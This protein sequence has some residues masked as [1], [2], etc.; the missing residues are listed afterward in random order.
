L[1]D[2]DRFHPLVR[3]WFG[4]YVGTPTDVQIRAWPQITGGNHVLVTAPTG[5]GKTLAAFLWAINS[6]IVNASSREERRV[7]YI[8]PLKALNNDIQRNLNLPLEQLRDV[9][10]SAGQEFPEIRVAVRS[11]DT[12]PSQRRQIVRHPPE[13]FIT[14]PESLNILLSS[15]SGRRVL[16]GI[17]TVILD[18]IHAV[19]PGRRGTFLMTAVERMISLSGEF[20]RI[21]LSAT[22]KPLKKVAEFVGG[23]RLI[24]NG[25][26][27]EYEK[28]PVQIVQSDAPKRY[29]IKVCY[30]SQPANI[31]KKEDWWASLTNDF[32]DVIHSNQSTLFFTNSRRMVE[33]VTRFINDKFEKDRVYSHHGSLSREIR[34]VVE[35][36]FKEGDLAAIVATSS[37]ELGIDIGSVDQVVLVQ[38][39]FSIASAIQRIGRAGHGVGQV[40]SGLFYPLHNH[41]FMESAVIAAHIDGKEIEEMVPLESPL[42]VLAQVILS[43]TLLEDRDIDELFAEL[44]A[45]YSYRH[46]GRKEFDL[47]LEM[48]AGR[49]ADA[50][51][52]ELKP[53]LL[54][55]RVKNTARAREHTAHLLYLSGGV[56][57]D[58]GY[59]NLRV[60]D[61][62]A[63]IGELDEE[64]VW[65]RSLGEAFPFGNQIWRIQKITHN[66]VE[67]A[68]VQ[69]SNTVIPFWRAEDMNRT[70][71]LSERIGGFLETAEQELKSPQFKTRLLERHHMDEAA[72]EQLIDYLMRQKKE[73]GAPLP[74]RH[75]VLVEH[76]HDPVNVRDTKQ[77][78]L[79]TYWGGRVNRPFAFALAAAWHESHGYPLELFVNNDCIILNLPHSFGIAEILALVKPDNLVPLLRK[80]LESTGF[81][82]ARFREN[83]QRALLLPRRSFHERMPLWLNRLRS[84]KLLEAVSRYEDFPVVLETWRDCLKN[85]FEIERLQQ[86]L[87]EVQ[88]GDIQVTEAMTRKP[89]PFAEGI[90]W[91]QTNYYM[92]EDDTPGGKLHSN[93]SDQLLKEVM[94]SSHLR[95]RF[96][97]RLI[98]ELQRKLQRTAEGYAPDSPEEL[99]LWLK[100]RLLIP[101][102][103]WEVLLAAIRRD[104]EV[105][106]REWLQRIEDRIFV[107]K[108]D[109]REIG[110]AALESRQRIESSLEAFLGEWLRFYGPVSAD[111][112]T[113]NL[114]IGDD[115]LAE[116]LDALVEDDKVLIDEFRQIETEEREPGPAEVCEAENVEILLRM[117]RSRARPVFEALPPGHLSLFLAQYQ[118]LTTPGD[119]L[120]DLQRSIEMLFG[121][122]ARVSLWET[123]ILP[124]RLAPYYPHWLDS[125]V[126]QN[127][128]SW[129]GCGNER[130]SF[131]F[132]SDFELFSG[133]LP[134]LDREE[135]ADKGQAK[136]TRELEEAL[137][138][139]VGRLTFDDISGIV[140]GAT[141]ELS[142]GLWDL[143]WRGRVTNDDYQTLRSGIMNRFKAETPARDNHVRGSQ[144]RSRRFGFNRWKQSRPFTGSWYP[145]EGVDGESIDALDRQEIVKD[146]IRLLLSRYGILMREMVWNELP[147]LRWS[148]IFPV[149]RLMELSG[150]IVSGH[151]FKEVA[152]LQF[153]SPQ[154]LRLLTR[155]LN[156]EA[157][158]W[159]NAA[160]PASL[161]GVPIDSIKA[162]LPHRLPTTHLVFQGA[163]LVLVSKK[164][165]KEL[166]FSVEPG[167]PRCEEFL[168]FF[169]ILV[170]REFQPLKYVNVETIN[171]V[172]ALES[173]FRHDLQANGFQRDYKSLML[174]KSY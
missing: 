120:E 6:L 53:R 39:P 57:P 44:R 79:H 91:R 81:F 65:E 70:F 103:E 72:A 29:H 143:A 9:F 42:D 100:E 7:L 110:M 109:G 86:L 27:V 32:M 106:V 156:H 101:M 26:M 24:Q 48:L 161:C 76:F 104:C 135:A 85:E 117:R 95:P 21:A 84:K 168:A 98:D 17:S 165:G 69:K 22:V 67:V 170:S 8:S 166:E 134:A 127:E 102:A 152:G 58:R 108:K 163:N 130:T 88:A 118:G 50:R 66:D 43:M 113:T 64:F 138:Q 11:G 61:S 173:P 151:F 123:D 150:E 133:A 140:R 77:T 14:T 132:Q 36:R 55:D 145:L 144:R 30:P 62:K 68:P 125:A 33:K 87:E 157:V 121:Y 54:L 169:K 46:L 80:K 146:R 59:Y 40:S 112:I 167:H 115:V 154:G 124:A 126:R 129:F 149:L 49:Y 51:I 35:K 92:Y 38:P 142:S 45:S 114:G 37:L 63:K 131:C 47:V 5:S 1:T 20:Q 147:G 122:P 153:I 141:Q 74:H 18:E 99:L 93:L 12:D 172:P 23:Y 52:R 159:M 16:E 41:A 164:N 119:M 73:T 139:A 19:A 155:G 71:H 10:E 162:L 96:S 28:R 34:S 116:A 89:S 97:D 75:H 31:K 160:D 82:G 15:K 148:T 128:L 137:G 111:F 56:I 158:Y 136:V 94:A 4:Q 78:V 60:A 83:A 13:I 105:D 3:K 107:F 25:E 174:V 171:G 2:L 90:I